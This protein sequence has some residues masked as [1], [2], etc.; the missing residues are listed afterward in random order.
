MVVADVLLVCYCLFVPVVWWGALG[1]T[2][3]HWASFYGKVDAVKCLVE[4]KADIEAKKNYGSFHFGHVFRLVAF[5]PLGFYIVF[6]RGC[7]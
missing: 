7:G 1:K 6:Y 2:P 3:L 4:L 5:N